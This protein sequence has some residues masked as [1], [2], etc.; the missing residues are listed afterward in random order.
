MRVTEVIQS[1]WTPPTP[2]E[3]DCLLRARARPRARWPRGA[4]RAPVPWR[5]TQGRAERRPTANAVRG[6]SS[7]SGS[8]SASILFAATST[9]LSASRSPAAS[10]PGKS[11]SSRGDDVE[12]LDRIAAGRRRHVDEVHQHLRA[13]EMAQEPMAEPVSGVRALDESRHV[14]HDERA[15]ARQ[16]DDAEVGNE[17]RERIVGNLRSG[18]RDAR[19]HRRLA[20]VRKA[21]Q[22]DVGEQL[23]VQPQI[24]ALRRAGRAA[25]GA[26]RGWSSS[27]YCA[28][29]QPPLPPLAMSTRCPAVVR[30][31]SWWS[32]PSGVFS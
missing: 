4:R 17:R 7:R 6:A 22:P 11:A 16:A 30:S 24:A 13:L 18:R 2:P 12:V 20:G 8:S 29:P 5:L 10:R 15:I 21:D 1:R 19:D 14:G 28:L 26:A 32:S 25:C 23:Q 31:A 27:R 3:L 9:G